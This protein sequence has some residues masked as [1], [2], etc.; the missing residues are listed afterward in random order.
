MK[1]LTTLFVVMM[2]VVV[3]CTDRKPASQF[4][5]GTEPYDS[6]AL[7]VALVPNRDCLPIYYA[8]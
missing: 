5:F 4:N 3:S 6:A 8:E 1:L 7:H 2:A